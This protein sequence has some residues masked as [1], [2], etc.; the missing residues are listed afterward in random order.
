MERKQA[1]TNGASGP[2]GKKSRAIRSDALRNEEVVIEA[3]KEVFAELGVDAPVR[4][5]AQRAN[6]GMGTLYRRFPKRSDLIAAVFRR[7]VDACTGEASSFASS[8]PPGEALASWLRR[9]ARFIAAKRGLAAA[10]HSGDP[11]YD[12]LPNYFRARFEPV[13]EALIAA[14]VE[15]KQVRSDI[16]AFDLLRVIGNISTASGNDGERH[17]MHMLELLIDGLKYRSLHADRLAPS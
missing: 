17:T 1:Q 13:L 11:A 12:A 9:Y 4:E 3:A 14:A 2:P 7:E 8:M 5:I 16:S 15:A 10:L 6:V